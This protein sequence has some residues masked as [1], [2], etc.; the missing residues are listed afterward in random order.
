MVC[1][2]RI[3]FGWDTTILKSGIWG[4]KNKI[5]ILRKSSLKLFKRS[6][7]KNKFLYIYGRKSTNIFMEHDLYLKGSYDAFLKIIILCI[8]CNR[9]CWH[10]LIFIK[11]ITFQI[12]YI[13]V[14]PLCPA[15]IKHFV[16]YKPRLLTSTVCSDWPAD[17]V[18][19]DWPNTTS[20][21]QKCNTLFHNRKLQL[22]K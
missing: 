2:D 18:H 15:S 14:G 1:Y 6:S 5:Y 11:H 3:I 16:F 22:S 10:A 20:T 17:T 19:C 9:I 21:S 12:L 4:C 8:W 7:S 13:I